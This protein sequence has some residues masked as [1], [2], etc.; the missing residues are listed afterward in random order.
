MSMFQGYI[1]I[2]GDFIKYVACCLAHSTTQMMVT[3][4]VVVVSDI[5]I[6]T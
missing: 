6:I 1:Q 5:L 2:K 4:G 3:F